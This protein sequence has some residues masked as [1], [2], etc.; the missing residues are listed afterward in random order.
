MDSLYVAGRTRVAPDAMVS[1]LR[2]TIRN[3][4]PRLPMADIHVMGE[5]VSEA[6]A[7]RRFQTTLLYG[8]R[9][10]CAR[11]GGDRS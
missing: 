9:R 11:A 2:R 4:D 3:I 8:I 6:A 5:L 1:T 10:C 7:R